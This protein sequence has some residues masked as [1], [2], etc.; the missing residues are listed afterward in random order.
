MS[1]RTFNKI[2]KKIF[3]LKLILL[4]ILLFSLITSNEYQNQKEKESLKFLENNQN[5]PSISQKTSLYLSNQKESIPHLAWISHKLV[6]ENNLIDQFDHINFRTIESND[7]QFRCN[8]LSLE[9]KGD[10]LNV[11]LIVVFRGTE[12]DLLKNIWADLNVTP[13]RLSGI[14]PG[15][16][17]HDGFFDAY[18]TIKEKVLSNLIE[19]IESLTN[20]GKVIENLYFS[21]HSLGGGIATI[22]T[23]DFLNR[24]TYKNLP[25]EKKYFPL[26]RNISLITFGCP[27]VGVIEF[28]DFF[29]QK[30][31]LRDNL[32]IAYGDD[33]VPD[34]VAGYPLS[35]YRHNGDFAHFP[36]NNFDNA[37]LFNRD[38][39]YKWKHPGGFIDKFNFY[40][41][42]QHHRKYFLLNPEGVEFAIRKFR[43]E[44]GQ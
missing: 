33:V 34:L 7:D 42:I 9:K 12:L 39:V 16:Q 30:D 1:N 23:Y 28:K 19:E 3:N 35:F 6:Y 21:G 17:V 26:V 10:D 29:N 25:K 38:E 40:K 13:K 2:L 22:G 44:R 32:R 4:S 41:K 11:D 31:L 5:I 18:E 20:R 24:R 43:E 8:I 36:E 15:C 27:R 14:C 37:E